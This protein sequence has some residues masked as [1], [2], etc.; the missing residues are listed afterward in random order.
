MENQFL[1][2][3]RSG[4][5]KA[6]Q[7][8]ADHA[9]VFVV[10]NRSQEIEIKDDSLDQ[11]KQSESQGVGLRVI[12]GNRQGFS[13]S[14]DFRSSAVDKMVTQAIANSTYNDEEPA[15]Y[16]PEQGRYYPQPDLYDAATG[17]HTMEEKIELAKETARQAKLYD[18]RVK[19]IERSG[20]EEG[21]IEMWL[22]NSHGLSLYQKGS[23]CGLFALALS[24]QDGEQQSGYGMNSCISYRD[25]S[26][27]E[28]G[29]MAGRRAVQLLGASQVKSGVMDLVL[30]PLIA[31][32]MMGIISS[33]FSGEAVLKNKSF[34]AGKLGEVVASRELTLIDDGT[35]PGRLGS[36]SFDGEGTAAQRTVL[37]ENGVLKNYLYDCL[38]A[39]KAG[40]VSTGN[41]M[42]GSY[43]GVPHI[44]ASNYYLEAGSL[45]PEQL[46]GS[47]EKGIYVTE[48]LGAHTANPVSGDFSFG[49]SGIL[50][51]HG[52]LSHPVRGITIA[53]NFQQLLQKISGIGSDLTFYGSQG[54]PTIR[55]SDISV[56]GK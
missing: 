15:L 31:M 18:S 24:E 55:I 5:A 28:A 45:S 30:E 22:A 19:S 54:A 9:E 51:E 4:L 41:G 21:E 25:L 32:Q 14:S 56:S 44:G 40:A 36:A 53:G 8:G 13:F 26:P 39:K 6:R 20:Y 43:K 11:I 27:E 12:K 1:E 35:M 37:L 46:I 49:A 34:L 48:I 23:F 50:I 47:V 38:S 52:K 3:A 2:F 16:F 29:K 7:M 33:C 10:K 17:A 42:R